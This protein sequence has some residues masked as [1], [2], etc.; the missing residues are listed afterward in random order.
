VVPSKPH[1]RADASEKLR[2]DSAALIAELK[3]LRVYQAELLRTSKEI[4]D[5]IAKHARK[6]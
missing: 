3:R 6:K 1:G 4:A 2:R 5:Q